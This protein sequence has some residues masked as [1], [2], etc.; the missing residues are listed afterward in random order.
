MAITGH[1][2]DDSW[3]L[4]SHILRFAYVPAPHDKDALCG[5][6]VN[7][8]FDW[9]LE[10]K[11]STITV[12]NSSTNNAMIK[13]LLDE[14]LNKNDLLLTG[15]VF[16]VCCAAHILNLIVQ[17]GLK[18]IGDSISKVR[19][20]V[21]D[22][23]G[24]AGRIERFE[25]AACLVHCS[26]YKKLEYDC[27]T[28]W[29]S[30]YL[31]LRTA[32]EYKEVFNKLSLTDTNYKSYPT[33]EQ[34]SNA[35]DVYD[36]LKLFYHITEQFSGTQYPTSSQYFTKVCEIK[37]EL[38]AWVKELNP[39]IS[40]MASAMLLKFKKYWDDVHILMGVAAIFDPRYKM[41]LVEFFLPLIYGEEASTKIQ[42]VRSNCYDLFQDYKSKLSAPH[43]SL[44]SSSSEVTS[45]T[46]GDRLSSFDRFLASTGAT[47]EKRSEL[48]M[49]LE[50]DLLPRTPSFDNLSR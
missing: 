21:L 8:L 49:Y 28:R 42:E 1:F 15:R 44:A 32:I 7:C 48:D 45:F 10:R 13:T 47:V 38:E 22:W 14:K 39:L 16:H 9:N 20:S 25:E 4:Q 37:L 34:W 36:K 17:E 11:I 18:V 5:A 6:L 50:E 40:D 29:N 12:D 46:Q 43:D 3:R 35:E 19:D 41:R 33:E 23:I 30:T 2:I 27:P 26:C 24:S 31:M